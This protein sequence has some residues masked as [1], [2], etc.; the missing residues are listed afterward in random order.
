MHASPASSLPPLRP[1]R[2]PRLATLSLPVLPPGHHSVSGSMNEAPRFWPSAPSPRHVQYCMPRGRAAT[3]L[4]PNKQAHVNHQ[5]TRRRLPV[6]LLPGLCIIA[7]G[8]PPVRVLPRIQ[9]EAACTGRRPP[10]HIV[11]R[12][13]PAWSGRLLAPLSNL[14][15]PPSS[16]LPTHPGAAWLA[17]ARACCRCRFSSG[18]QGANAVAAGSLVGAPRACAAVFGNRRLFPVPSEPLVGG[19]VP[20]ASAQVAAHGGP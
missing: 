11:G 6:A 3:S 20:I 4:P 7:G 19:A 17:C 12:A 5:P 10:L 15:P 2:L 16:S 13:Q 18:L 9:Q 14:N 1:A 8:C